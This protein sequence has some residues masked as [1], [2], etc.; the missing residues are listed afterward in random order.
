MPTL[1]FIAPRLADVVRSGFSK[2]K[3]IGGSANVASFNMIY[4]AP[5]NATSLFCIISPKLL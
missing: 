5:S 2:S 1:R 4:V 3:W